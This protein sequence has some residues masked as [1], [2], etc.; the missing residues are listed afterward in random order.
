MMSPSTN[1]F[2]VI[3]EELVDPNYLKILIKKINFIKNEKFKLN[4]SYFK[5]S[6]KKDINIAYSKDTYEN[7][8]NLYEKFKF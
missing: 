2:F 3:Y 6:N 4:L 8:K 7:A 1:C 5:N